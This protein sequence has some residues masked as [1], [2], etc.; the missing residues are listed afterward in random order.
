MRI[1]ISSLHW[2]QFKELKRQ[3]QRECQRSYNKYVSDIIRDSY[4]TSKK[5]KL[6]SY[7]KHLQKDHCGI[8]MLQK[9][10]V[11]YCKSKYSEPVLFLCFYKRQ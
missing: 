3:M 8:P 10:G 4:E 9:D 6:F 11:E 7:I 5:K 1:H 2:T